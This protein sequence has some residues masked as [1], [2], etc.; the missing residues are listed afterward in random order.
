MA[1]RDETKSWS[2]DSLDTC[3]EGFSSFNLTEIFE[4]VGFILD[5]MSSVSVF[6]WCLCFALNKL[7]QLCYSLKL[8]HHLYL[9]NC[10]TSCVTAAR[11]RL[12]EQF[13]ISTF[14]QCSLDSTMVGVGWIVLF[15]SSL[16]V[17]TV[18]QFFLSYALSK[19]FS[20]A[21]C[22]PNYEWDQVMNVG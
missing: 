7:V 1:S 18:L 4:V 19:V 13:N 8:I 15:I 22:W 5:R 16:Q 9:A 20:R 17:Q 14:C 10:L 11:K 12:S 21:Y 2:V 6:N 3:F